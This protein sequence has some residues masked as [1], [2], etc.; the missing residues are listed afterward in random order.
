[1]LFCWKLKPTEEHVCLTHCKNV[2]GFPRK[3]TDEEIGTAVIQELYE[4]A[5]S[6]VYRMLKRY[7]ESTEK[8]PDSSVEE[9]EVS[10]ETQ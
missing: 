1:M 10:Q 7:E 3:N 2:I 6:S 5:P 4:T 8:L 9:Q